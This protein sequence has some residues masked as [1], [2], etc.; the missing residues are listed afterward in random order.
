[1]MLIPT[2]MANFAESNVSI[3]QTLT[4]KLSK[5]ERYE[6][7]HFQN[8]RHHGNRPCAEHTVGQRSDSEGA[9]D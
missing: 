5:N 1:M 8:V 7:K 3:N 4:H 2:K 6:D 9:I